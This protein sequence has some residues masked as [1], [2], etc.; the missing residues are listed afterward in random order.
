[1]VAD[2]IRNLAEDSN[3]FTLEIKEIIKTLT[4][5]TE[6]AVLN[7]NKAEKIVNNQNELI[8]KFQI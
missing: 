7:M 6:N 5:K 1:M 4:D 8:M 3:K 2:E